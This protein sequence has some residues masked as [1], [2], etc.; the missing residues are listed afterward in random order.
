MDNEEDVDVLRLA[1]RA[2][3][4]RPPRDVDLVRTDFA[5]KI[6]PC[7]VGLYP[8]AGVFQRGG[9]VRTRKGGP[10]NRTFGTT[11]L[12]EKARSNVHTG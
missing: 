4:V 1:N 2:D 3:A 8:E 10:S 7:L 5:R 12:S 11:T 6:C 9:S